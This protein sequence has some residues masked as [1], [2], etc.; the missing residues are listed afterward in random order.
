MDDALESRKALLHELADGARKIALHFYGRQDLGVELKSDAS[1][2]T[3]ADR[4]IEEYLRT[5]IQSRFPHDG[6]LGEEL[7][8]SCGESAFR[9]ILDPIDGTVSFANRVPLFGILIALAHRN[10]NGQD[11]TVLAGVADF[12]ALG[13]RVIA[14]RGSGAQWIRDGSATQ[15]AKVRQCDRIADALICTSGSEYYIKADRVDA[16]VRLA[17]CCGRIRG[18][19]DCY[20]LLLVATGRADAMVDPIMHPWDIGPFAVIMPEAGGVIT[21]WS[22]ARRLDGGNAIA[23]SPRLAVQLRLALQR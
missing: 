7:G 2:V 16:F 1:P 14:Q 18:W 12:P 11:E 13:E 15:V 3:Q 10:A 23:A 21:D 9:W 17:N 8:E 19:S 4:G 20:G 5:T 6:V 22:G